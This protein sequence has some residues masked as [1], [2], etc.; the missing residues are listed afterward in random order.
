MTEERTSTSGVDDHVKSRSK[1]GTNTEVKE[2]GE[3]E[4][5]LKGNGCKSIAKR[6]PGGESGYSSSRGW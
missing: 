4:A 3:G 5:E 2:A 1:G 6:G